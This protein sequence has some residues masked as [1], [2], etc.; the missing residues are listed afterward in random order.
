MRTLNEKEMSIVAGGVQPITGPEP[1][2]LGGSDEDDAFWQSHL[3][4]LQSNGDDS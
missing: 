1:N 2:P 4:S 3:F